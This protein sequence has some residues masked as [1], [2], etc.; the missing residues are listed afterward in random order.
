MVD[1]HRS[2]D[3]QQAPNIHK[4]GGSSLSDSKQISKVVETIKNKVSRGDFVVVSANGKV[5]DYLLAYSQGKKQALVHLTGYLN[6]LITS[7]LQS[8]EQLN[9][10]VHRDLN[11]LSNSA[12]QSS[13]NLHEVLA[14]GELWSAQLLSAKLKEE[15]VSCEWLDAREYLVVDEQSLLVN[16]DVAKNKLAQ[17]SNLCNDSDDGLFCQVITGFIASDLSGNCITLGRNGSD[18]SAT[19]LADLVQSETV[20]LWTDVDGVYTADPHVISQARPIEQLTLSEAQALSELGSNVLHQKTMAPILQQPIKLV[21]NTCDSTSAGTV[22]DRQGIKAKVFN[23][24]ST[25]HGVKTLAHKSN[26]V[27]LSVAQVNEL[28]ARQLQTLLTAKQ[29][30]NY[31]NHFD[32][33]QNILSFYVESADLFHS[34]QLLKSS[35][36]SL[37]TQLSEISLISVV[38]QQIRQNHQVIT[39]VLNRSAQFNIH[40]IHYPANDH[41]LCVLLPDEQAVELLNDLHQ[42][43]FGL[44]PSMPI[45]VLGYGNIGQQFLKILKNNKSK[46]ETSVNQSLSVVAVANSRYFQFNE[47]CLLEHQID[48]NQPNLNGELIDALQVYAGKPAVIVDL[49]ASDW[50]AKQYLGFAQNGW[51]I[52]SANKIAAADRDYTQ[53]INQ[54]LKLNKRQWLKNTTVGAALPIQDSIKKVQLSGDQIRSVT[55]VFSG[56]LSWLFGQYDGKK[57]FMEWLKLA[58][59]NAYTE[60]DPREDLSG[61]DV[62]RKALILAQ[63]LGFA[64]IKITFNPVVP[65]EFLMG[66]LDEFWQNKAAINSH[67]ETL[68]QQAQTEQKHL[69]YLATVNADELRV[70]LLSVGNDHP[71]KG[72]QPGDNIF[73]IESAWY[74]ANPLVIQGPGA[75]REVTA[76]GVLT[77]LIE[78][79]QS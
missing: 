36:L 29:I 25:S 15:N 65:E 21:I 30:N 64:P 49:T 13:R 71:A 32:K 18:Y 1:L 47:S 73:I 61:Q 31:A 79:L 20:Y 41:T 59:E 50:V 38:G 78:V 44:E 23:S 52:I 68:W 5:T 48:L 39:K 19:L 26:L 35:G 22:V 43:F 46:I 3:H 24:V 11:L 53:S 7:V 57:T 16:K 42:T 51:H 17:A 76:S 63:E 45:V 74:S 8:P 9:Q 27:Y 40:N 14:L 72:L 2:P 56:S 75:G 77:D 4:F 12:Q 10:I 70:E 28:K 33:T 34:T 55:G 37:K 60:P 54:S 62:Y 6:Q 67:I 66:S 58:H 69:R